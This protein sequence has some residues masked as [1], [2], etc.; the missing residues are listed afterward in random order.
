ML[1]T[2]WV[3]YV[4]AAL[5]CAQLSAQIH[6]AGIAVHGCSTGVHSEAQDKG[7]IDTMIQRSSSHGDE[8]STRWKIET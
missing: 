8:G 5:G 7:V 3:S 1:M 4:L 6:A 2:L